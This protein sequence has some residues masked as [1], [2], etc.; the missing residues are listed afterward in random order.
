[1]L[2]TRVVTV[3]VRYP[4]EEYSPA[5]AAEPWPSPGV[6]E[7]LGVGQLFVNEGPLSAVN[8]LLRMVANDECR[9]VMILPIDLAWIFHPY[10][11]GADVITATSA[12]RDLLSTR[13]SSWRSARP[14]GL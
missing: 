8:G 5:L 9:G 10:D 2:E 12:E 4:E 13:F 11:G 3:T 6:A 1:M 7:E 14:D